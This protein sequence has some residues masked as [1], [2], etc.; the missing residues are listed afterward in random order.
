M[1]NSKYLQALTNT[2]SME[3]LWDMHCKKMAEYGFDRLLYGFTR[4]RTS[5]SLGD[6]EDFIVLSNHTSGYTEVFMGE[7]LYFHGPM[8]KWV[9]DNEGAAS[10]SMLGDMRRADGK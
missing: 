9:L 6:P 1:K 2:Q 8:V 10:W 5:R 3:E 7:G 4:Y